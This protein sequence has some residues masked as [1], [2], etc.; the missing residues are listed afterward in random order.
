MKTRMSALNGKVCRCAAVFAALVLAL[1]APS[2]G[3][4]VYI[5]G[6]TALTSRAPGWAPSLATPEAPPGSIVP[7]I[8]GGAGIW[9]GD[10]AIEAS[11]SML[12]AQSIAWHFGYLF[13][14]RGDKITA[15]RDLP[16]SG[17]VRVA[18]LR[19]RTVSIEPLIG[20]GVS[21]HRAA[22]MTTADCGSGSIVTQVCVP[23]TPPRDD[24]VNT[25]ADWMFT[26]GADVAIRASPHLAIVP[27]VR[28]SFVK[29]AP[30]MTGYGHRG[31]A[32]GA[33]HLWSI[34]VTARYTL[35]ASGYGNRAIRS[36]R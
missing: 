4:D 2:A 26:A 32:S 16:V 10:A 18:P 6:G 29:R 28:G 34:G 30:Y 24:E 5:V 11:I 36:A 19:H 35:H 7:S 3:Q 14:N 22:T 17:L 15:D 9:L 20:G 21:F 25:T 12:R 31:P 8:S 13:G 1:A 33:G 23:I 27:G